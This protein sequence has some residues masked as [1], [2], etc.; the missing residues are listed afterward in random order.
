LARAWIFRE[1]QDEYLLVLSGHHLVC[2]G[3]SMGVLV[4][5][6]G[7]LYQA[8]RRGQ[9][10]A[11]PMPAVQYADY[12][13]WQ[14]S[15]LNGEVLQAQLAYW[16]EELAGLRPLE[17]PAD[18]PRTA[19]AAHRGACVRFR[20]SAELTRQLQ[21][22]SRE[23]GTTMFML[24][25]ASFEVL[26]HRYTGQTDLAVG[27]PVAGRSRKEL[28]DV[29]GSFVNTIVL[30]GDLSGNPTFRT[31]LERVRATALAGFAHQDAPFE[32]VVEA[33]AP[34]RDLS[35]SP[36]FQVM[37]VLQNTPTT[38][39]ALGDLKAEWVPVETGTAKFD[40]LLSMSEADG[41]LHGA[42]E[43][44]AEL[45]DQARIERLVRH[46]ERLLEAIAAD[47]DATIMALPILSEG[48]QAQIQQWTQG[49]AVEL[50]QATIPELFHVHAT[51]R[52]DAIAVEDAAGTLTY[53]ALDQVSNRLAAV[54]QARGV[55]PEVRV[56]VY[57]ERSRELIIALVAILKA[58]GVYVPI[59]PELPLER[60]RFLLQDSGA[61]LVLYSAE[62]EHDR[63]LHAA[64]PQIR[65]ENACY[66]MYT[67]GSTGVPKGVIVSHRA[68]VRL[69]CHPD[70]VRLGSDER[71][72]H[73][74]PTAFDASTFEIWGA[75]LNGARLVLH[76]GPSADLPALART[77]VQYRVTTLWLTAAL[78]H[79][80]VDHHM[81]AFG[82]VRQLLA[83]G[84]ALSPADV[85]ATVEG[86]P[87]C[88]LINGYGPTEATTF[89]CCHPFSGEDAR[90]G[91][92][93][94]GRPITNTRVFILDRLLSPAPIGVAGEMYIAGPGLARG[95]L[96]RQHL[97]AEAFLPNPWADCPG[98][99]MYRSGD[100]GR[101]TEAGTIEFLGRVD[102][103]V[104]IRGYRVAPGE[105]EAALRA[106][107]GVKDA[108]VT[109]A[110]QAAERRLVAYVVWSVESHGG[111]AELLAELRK[112]LP[113]YML[114]SAFVDLPQLPLTAN[115]K[116]D[117]AM[118]ST[119]PAP[120]MGADQPYEA[121]CD[122]LESTL[123]SIWQ[124]VLGIGRVGRFDNFF[125]IGGHSLLA[126]QVVSRIRESLG[127]QLAIADLFRHA[128]LAG[129]AAWTREVQQ[130]ERD[131][132]IGNALLDQLEELSEE[133]VEKLFSNTGAAGTD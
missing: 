61:D 130:S 56:G 3:W 85:R 19:V 65:P 126:S 13:V 69:V 72:L 68:V 114:P 39:L 67:S 59:D 21:S 109:V 71:I 120:Q 105:V 80:M 12:A 108:C 86:L 47:V 128:T 50:P 37:F 74:A 116:I 32:K 83:G 76:S 66:V 8:A 28:E 24:L 9:A 38:E 94:I 36:L 7:A 33:L 88:Q 99:R 31:M 35:R 129:L 6:L 17:L 1:A 22:V 100:L 111:P 4:R 30:R 16:R 92:V 54:L 63:V 123:A 11:L 132:D 46:W 118:L 45:F 131:M 107:P 98:E 84:D 87:D 5:E 122:E 2:D 40:L 96:N 41:Q 101:W 42:F 124:D 64:T 43:Y 103:Q 104:K 52:P 70:Y 93:P 15:W 79:A 115:G 23:H 121:P 58:G 113:D 119:A 112:S 26:L 90:L 77:I 29:V 48:E 78:F 62:F 27:T 10:A 133:E 91:H 102:D 18:R 117:R 51:R 97:T 95:Y 25:L 57:L 106:L 110:G 14:R 125:D 81:D 53:G 89:S 34:V 44:D 55:G 73:C 127:I 75:L 20:L 49:P 60:R 82:G